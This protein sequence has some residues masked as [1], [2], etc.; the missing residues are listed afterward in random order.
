MDEIFTAL[1]G[2]VGGKITSLQWELE[3]KKVNLRYVIR[4][5]KKYINSIDETLPEKD[6]AVPLLCASTKIGS[7]LDKRGWYENTARK[8]KESRT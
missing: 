4:D 5:A 7:S 1:D 2:I 6:L 8:P 3:Q